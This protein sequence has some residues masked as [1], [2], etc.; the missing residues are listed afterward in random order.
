MTYTRVYKTPF[1]KFVKKAKSSLALAI[2]MAIDCICEA[3]Y[4]G[5]EKTGDLSG[6]KVHKFKFQGQEYLIAYR[7]INSNSAHSPAQIELL[8]IEF[9]QVGTHENFYDMLKSYLKH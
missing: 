5:V 4:N 3:P 2:D 8:G 6:I 1:R 9:Y 7:L